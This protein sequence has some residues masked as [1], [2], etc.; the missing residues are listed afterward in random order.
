MSSLPRGFEPQTPEDLGSQSLAELQEMLKCQERL[1]GDEKFICKLP[2]KGKKVLGSVVKLKAAIAEREEARVKSEL[3]D[4]VSVDCKLRQK[5]IAVIDVDTDKAQNSAQ[6]LGTSSLVPS[7]SSIDTIKLCKATSEQQGLAHP[8]HKGDE[9]APEV[10]YTVNKCPASSSRTSA[11]SSSEASHKGSQLWTQMSTTHKKI[12]V[13][14]MR[15][16]LV[17]GHRRNL[18]TWKC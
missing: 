14:R 4:P 13:L 9:E 8:T 12:L 2:D 15:Q 3:F 10:E 7:S 5:A 6:I 16:A 18:L 17:V 1:L 11:P